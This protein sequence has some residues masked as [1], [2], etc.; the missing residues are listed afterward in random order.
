[1]VIETEYRQNY[2]DSLCSACKCEHEIESYAE[3]DTGYF[4]TKC[5]LLN[6]EC[7]L[8]ECPFNYKS[9]IIL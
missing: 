8:D 7:R 6:T 2:K 3:Y 5:H 9:T 4:E 1:M